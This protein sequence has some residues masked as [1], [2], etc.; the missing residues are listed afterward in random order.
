MNKHDK[1]K[2]VS[3]QQENQNRNCRQAFVV[4]LHVRR[5]HPIYFLFMSIHRPISNSN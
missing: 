1:N 2:G 4:I 3:K 5:R